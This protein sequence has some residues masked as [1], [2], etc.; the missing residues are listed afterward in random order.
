MKIEELEKTVEEATARDAEL[1]KVADQARSLKDEVDILRETADKVIRML[2]FF[3]D[4]CILPPPLYNRV[5]IK[6]AY[7]FTF[8]CEKLLGGKI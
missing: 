8:F 6:I 7:E 1:Q 4:M 3:Q 2:E 5:P